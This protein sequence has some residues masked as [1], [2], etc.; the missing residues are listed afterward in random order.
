MARC[1]AILGMLL[2]AAAVSAQ[3]LEIVHNFAASSGTPRGELLAMPDGSFYGTTE[4]GGRFQ[5]GSVFRL[6]PDGL[7]GFTI[8]EIHSFF[9][10]DGQGPRAGLVLDPNGW[11]YGT[12]SGGLISL[13]TIFAMDPAGHVTRLHQFSGP[14]GDSP[15]GPLLLGSDGFFYG[16]TFYGGANNFG[17]VFRCDHDGNVTTIHSFSSTADGQGPSA[18]LVHGPAGTGTLWGT[19]LSGGPQVGGTVFRIDPDGTHTVVHGFSGPDGMA[20]SA[21]LLL[22]SDGNFYGT[23]STGGDDQA[24]TIFR[25]TPAGGF[26]TVRSLVAAEG[27]EPAAPLLEVAPGVFVGTAV[28]GGAGNEGTVFQVTSGGAYTLL[29]DFGPGF[30]GG[31]FPRGGL[32][33]ANGSLYGAA[34][35]GGAEIRGAVYRLD[36]SGN[37]YEVLAS[38]EDP[39]GGQSRGAL[40]E[41]SDGKLYG[42][43][44]L[45]NTVFRIGPSDAFE[46]FHRLL[47]S[48]GQ[49]V[50]GG[51]ATGPDGALYGAAQD[52]GANG[53]GSVFRLDVASGQ[54]DVLHS[55]DGLGGQG[56]IGGLLLGSDD[57]LYGSTADG[58]ANI[59][60][61][62]FRIDTSGSF[63]KLWDF[64][65]A[66]GAS[67]H[68]PLTEGLDGFFYGTAYIG[69]GGG[70]TVFR[71]DPTTGVT[72]V[73]TLEPLDGQYSQ[74]ALVEISDGVFYGTGS[75]G[76]AN[77]EGTIFSINAVG[78]LTV[79]HDFTSANYGGIHPESGLILASDGDFYGTTYNG[80]LG[81]GT[82][83]RLDELGALTT[84]YDFGGWEGG[85]PLARLTE[86]A[87]GNLYGTTFDGGIV[88]RGTVFRLNLDGSFAP[89]LISIEPTSGP[90][91]GGRALTLTGVHFQPYSSVQIG[92]ETFSPV[93]VDSRTILLI[94]H[95]APPGT[96]NDVTVYNSNPSFTSSTLP[97]GFFADFLDVPGP[98]AFH[99]FVE[100]ILRAGITAGCGGGTYCVNAPVTRAQ[101]AVFLLK[102]EHGSSYTPPPC[103]G[104]FA[105]VV[106]P[107]TFADWIEQLAA[108]GVTSGCGGGNYC[109][110]NP[111]TR[112]QMAVFLLKTLLGSAYV[113]PLATGIFG[114]V[115]VGSFAADW[116]EDLYGRA[117]TGGCNASPLL[118]C[119]TNSNTRGQMA[120]FLVKTFGL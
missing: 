76:G 77:G 18:G 6:V 47:P 115:P 117:I 110:A 15:R 28:N 120:V 70:G 100:A 21:P 90:A 54:L 118:Y 43:T 62:L 42:T 111:V 19:T 80:G 14:D 2:L 63:T 27:F 34:S 30:S 75:N 119:P 103:R 58:G 101:M 97:G 69:G 66:D 105:D 48:E 5:M 112:A 61:T 65:G 84:V 17:T 83:Y 72:L 56:P 78:S 86:A 45:N 68:A 3:T 81:L 89:T 40:V 82:V 74:S 96:L 20:P 64:T 32:V 73:R 106:C 13:G 85:H 9:G 109:P 35:L 95:M 98:H 8:D 29:H 46:V 51:L 25:L 36:P 55:F 107:G 108:E 94:S 60:G 44:T 92:D 59:V 88:G 79:L 99:A 116:I 37:N 71:L 23:T 24:G 67:P 57:L 33:L 11:L 4:F 41:A 22:A 104:T 87:D 49:D 1:A 12:T 113:P 7:G 52:G 39:E 26:S 31:A 53:K 93:T 16:T 114:D 38:F 10:R 91:E 102:A 50:L